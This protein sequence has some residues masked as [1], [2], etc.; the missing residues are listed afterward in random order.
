MAHNYDT[1]KATEP[2]PSG[3]ACIDCH[4]REA[5]ASDGLCS[6]CADLASRPDGKAPRETISCGCC[7]GPEG[8]RCACW[9]H[10][11]TTPTT[12][13]VTKDGRRVA[14]ACTDCRQPAL[15]LSDELF[16]RGL[17]ADAGEEW[18]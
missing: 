12:L 9:I 6:E 16:A 14:H 17:A 2:T 7:R 15:S 10:R 11:Y 8:D 3:E 18:F 4:R 5:D 13:A 1:W